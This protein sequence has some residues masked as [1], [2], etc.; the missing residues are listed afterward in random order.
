[1]KQLY[2]I[3]F[4]ALAAYSAALLITEANTSQAFV[5]HYFSD[6]DGGRPLFAINTTLS[7]F[8]LAGAAI[9]LMFAACS[10]RPEMTR[11]SRWLM[12]TQAAMLGFLAFDD[13]FQVHEALAYRV[14]IADHYIMAAWAAL[15]TA[16]LLALARLDQVPLRSFGLVVAGC[17]FFAVMMLFDSAIPHDAYLRLSIE[18]LAKSWAAAL[19][20]AAAWGL[21]RF[22]LGL[23]PQAQTLADWLRAHPKSRVSEDLSAL[24]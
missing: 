2:S 17:G 6:I 3:F 19:F 16:L 18:D 11:E 14:G 1:M 21:A 9:L 8:L 15:E 22:Q 13:R 12:W 7:T 4:A 23:D 20:F 24:D 10:G 5:R